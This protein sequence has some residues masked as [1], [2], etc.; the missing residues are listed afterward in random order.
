MSNKSP[1]SLPA[2]ITIAFSNAISAASFDCTKASTLVE[3]TICTDTQLS[4]ADEQMARLYHK[5]IGFSA[6]GDNT[7][8]SEQR[9]W[10]RAVR[11][12]CKSAKNASQCLV[13]KYSSR[14]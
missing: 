6:E 10:L 5:A 12:E 2:I 11:Q 7:I 8:Q 13:D 14:T 3:K 1:L 9:R 4:K